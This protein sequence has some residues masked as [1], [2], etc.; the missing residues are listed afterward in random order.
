MWQNHWWRALKRY[1]GCLIIIIIIIIIMVAVIIP[2]N[3]I[4]IIFIMVKIMIMIMMIIARW[5][6]RLLSSAKASGCCQA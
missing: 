3:I 4:I 6:K 2:I 5:Q 1:Q